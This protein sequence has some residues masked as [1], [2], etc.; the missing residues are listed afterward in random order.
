MH[1]ALQTA[2][3]IYEALQIPWHAWPALGETAMRTWSRIQE[4][5]ATGTD[6][7]T[8]LAAKMEARGVT[9]IPDS[10]PPDEAL[11]EA[12]PGIQYTQPFEWSDTWGAQPLCLEGQEAAYQ[13][14]EQVVEALLSRHSGTDVRIAVVGHGNFGSVMM[15]VLTSSAPTPFSRF[16]QFNGAISRVDIS[17]DGKTSLRFLN[18]VGHL[19]AEM[20]RDEL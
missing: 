16:T 2:R 10:A 20:V 13:R 9:Y 14:G 5:E 3:P 6:G 15:S 8:A 12:Y 17:D 4:L 18:Y 1:R 11:Q 19:P 7:A